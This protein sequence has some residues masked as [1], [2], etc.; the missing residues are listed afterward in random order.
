MTTR[1][2]ELWQKYQHD[3]WIG[4]T[5]FAAAIHDY[6]A[7]VRARDAEIATEATAHTAYQSKECYRFASHLAA[8]ISSEELP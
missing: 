4:P 2:D 7:A 6:G 3:G 5:A 8:T 1:S